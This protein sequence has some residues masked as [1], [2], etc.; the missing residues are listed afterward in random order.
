[1]TESKTA[2]PA[3]LTPGEWAF[4]EGRAETSSMSVIH[5]ADDPGFIIGYAVCEGK[6]KR[7]RAEDLANV[8]VMSLAPKMLKLLQQ[9]W[10]ET[11]SCPLFEDK[12]AALINAAEGTEK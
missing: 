12:I 9:I 5:K 2:K 6:N 10:F 1:M 8:R 4:T 3:G 11:S 7:Q